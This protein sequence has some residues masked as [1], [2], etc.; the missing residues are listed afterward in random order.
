MITFTKTLHLTSYLNDEKLKTFSLRSGT[1]QRRPFSLL[2]FSIVVE[3]LANAIRQE[4]EIQVFQIG[5]EDIKLSLFTDDMIVYVE[6][7]KESTEK[8]LEL[9]SDY[10]K[11]AGHIVNI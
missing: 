2:L 11:V 7:S 5:K 9:I 10:N 6:N 3:V 4:K 8:L 1:R